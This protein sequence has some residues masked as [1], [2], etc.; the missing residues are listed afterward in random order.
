M[1]VKALLSDPEHVTAAMTISQALLAVKIDLQY[2]FWVSLEEK[3]T[4]AGY[5]ITE[6][7][8]YSRR[9][10]EAYYTKGVR[11]YGM[12]IHLPELMDQEIIAFFIGVSHRVYYGFIP[13]EGGSPVNM[14]NDPGF[15]LLSDILKA[16]DEA[17]SSSPTMLGWR[18]SQRNFDFFSFNYTRYTGTH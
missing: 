1:D 7:W 17:W 13:L 9:S 5:E 2:K 3:L 10:V 4:A 11:R 6:Y 8:K 12:L 15:E 18:P 16:S 14:T